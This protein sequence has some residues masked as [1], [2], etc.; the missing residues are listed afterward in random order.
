MRTTFI[1]ELEPQLVDFINNQPDFVDPSMFV[2]QT[3]REE[4]NRSGSTHLK[5]NEVA[6]HHDEVH[7]AL[8]EFLNENTQ[9]AD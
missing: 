6:Y 3:L 1:L 7:E 4:K 5:G 9:A 8:E 2:N